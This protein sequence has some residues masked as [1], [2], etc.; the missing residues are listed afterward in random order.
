MNELEKLESFLI[1]NGYKHERIDYTTPHGYDQHQII[2][3]N[4]KHK[5]IWD[6]VCHYGSYGHSQGLLEIMGCI[7]RGK[8]S[9]EGWLTADDVI[10]RFKEWED[11]WKR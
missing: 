8:D 6:A 1:Q 4:D 10:K 9:V 3:Y 2:V 7:V 11:V 5:R